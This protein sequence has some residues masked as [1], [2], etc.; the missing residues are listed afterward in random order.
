[1]LDH[2]SR[3]STSLRSSVCSDLRHIS[4]FPRHVLQ[5]LRFFMHQVCR[6]PGQGM[7]SPVGYCF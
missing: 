4:S 1:M 7:M 5:F 6:L 2:S 3:F